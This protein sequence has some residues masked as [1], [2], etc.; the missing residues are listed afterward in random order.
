MAIRK[1][2]KGGKNA[3]SV[4]SFWGVAPGQP[5]ITSVTPGFGGAYMSSTASVAFNKNTMGSTPSSYTIFA[6]S[7][8]GTKTFTG[9]TSS[10]YTV[11][12]LRAGTTYAFTILA[13]AR[14]AQATTDIE[15]VSSLQTNA[16]V[17]G[18][19]DAP[20]GVT[21]SSPSSATYDTVS[22]SA[23]ADN[24]GA[25]ITNYQIESSD[26]KSGTVNALTTN[27]GQEAGTAQTYRVRAYNAQ[28]WS[29]WSA[30]SA[31]V[32]TFSF[33]PFSVFGFSPFGVFGF[34]PF[35][36]F[37]F[38]PFSVFGFSPFGFSPFGVFGFSPFG[39][40]PFGVFGFSPFGFSPF[41][42]GGCIHE[43]T[44]VSVTNEAGDYTQ[45]PVKDV[46]A[47]QEIWCYSFDEL[48][49]ESEG[50]P[51]GMSLQTLSNAKLV[52]T[53]VANITQK[54]MPATMWLNGQSNKKFST[55][56][57][58][59]VKRNGQYIYI[60]SGQIV[61]GDYV[62]EYNH[63]LAQFTEVEVTAVDTDNTEATVYR[64]DAEP[65]DTLIGGDY[66]LHN[67]KARVY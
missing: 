59:L 39:F 7:V 55:M 27:I 28:G 45:I 61:I 57:G 36:V 41:G 24:G 35:G 10:P 5:Y 48:E 8:Y 21:A 49:D 40:S 32:T 43:D 6:N 37:G 29:E 63:N 66:L 1:G 18:V 14:L 11:T 3:K 42:F 17:V 15:S 67:P 52:K 9:V 51:Y 38:S 2:G 56:Q 58:F 22:W 62:L 31:S 54:T 19:P 30:W 20:T 50:N 46:V 26:G 25:V 34:S 60:E 13:V 65:I 47:G 44:L 64:I 33:V 23:P 4:V 16:P 12:G 53:N